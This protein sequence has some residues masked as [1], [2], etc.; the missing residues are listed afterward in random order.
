MELI[1]D[2]RE[3]HVINQIEKIFKIT[4]SKYENLILKKENLDLGDF[5][6][7]NILIERKTHQDLASSILDGRYK[8][9]CSRLS[10]F[11]CE[12]P[13]TKIY[14]FIEGNFDLFI[15]KHNIDKDKL[16]TCI[17]SLSYEKN[18]N[19]YTCV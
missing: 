12:N 7:G 16:I 11:L 14:Y 15:N 17:M 9:Q 6:F 5:K 3:T 8:E 1:C 19:I 18:F 10:S 2:Y 4:N 13:N